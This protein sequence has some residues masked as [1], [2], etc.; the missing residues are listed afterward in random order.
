VRIPAD[1]NQYRGWPF[2]IQ[3][4]IIG[5]DAFSYYAASPFQPGTRKGLDDVLCLSSSEVL[6]CDAEI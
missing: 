2:S 1:G 4:D 6:T 3:R 5:V